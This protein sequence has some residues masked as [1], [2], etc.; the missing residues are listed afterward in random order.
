MKH[1]NKLTMIYNTLDDLIGRLYD[2]SLEQARTC[3]CLTKT[4][5]YELNLMRNET[6]DPHDDEDYCTSRSSVSTDQKRQHELVLINSLRRTVI[7][8]ENDTR[9]HYNISKSESEC[10]PKHI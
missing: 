1:E 9:T 2:S 8:T 4:D 7:I 5:P 10:G 3:M 6:L